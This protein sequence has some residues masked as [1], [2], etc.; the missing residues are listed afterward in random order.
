[1]LLARIEALGP[2][3]PRVAVQLRHPGAPILTLLQEARVLARICERFGMPLFVNGRLEVALRVG[4][5]LHLPTRGLRPADVRPHLP[6]DRW[7]SA[8]AHDRAEVEDAQ[9][10]DLLLLSPVFPPHSKEAARAPLGVE[11]LTTLASHTQARPY[12]LGGVD[13]ETARTL[14]APFG[15]AAVGAVLHAADPRQ[16]AEALLRSR[17]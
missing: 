5:H 16:A 17:G 14:P 9:G 6:P 7:I 13:P 15:L 4:A 3:G 10:A 8:A 11:G 1:V 12:A 2:L